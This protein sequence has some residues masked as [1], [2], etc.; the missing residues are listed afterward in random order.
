M[1]FVEDIESECPACRGERFRPE[2][3]DVTHRVRQLHRFGN[4]C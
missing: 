2:V 3:L 1:E 4:V